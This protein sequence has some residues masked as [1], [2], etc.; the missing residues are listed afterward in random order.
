[1][2]LAYN[3][4]QYLE[5]INVFPSASAPFLVNLFICLSLVLKMYWFS[6]DTDDQLEPES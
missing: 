3:L 6:G 1:M 2:W 4:V 5:L